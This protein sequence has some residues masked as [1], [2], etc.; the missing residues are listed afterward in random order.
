MGRG[1]DRAPGADA[2]LIGATV[3]G[4]YV[5]EARL[6]EGGMGVIY[7]ARQ[8]PLDRVV[9]LK[10]LSLRQ[11]EVDGDF[12]RRFYLEAA[13]CAK[14]SH[15]NIVVVHDYGRLEPE[16]GGACF[17]VMELVEGRTV[18]EVIAAEGPFEPMRVIRVMRDVGRALRAAHRRDVIHRD[19]KPSNVMLEKTPEGERV[20]VLDFGLVK[21]LEDDGEQITQEGE[22]L[23]SPRFMSPEQIEH[24]PLDPR[25]D[26]YSLGALAY[27]TAT[28]HAPFERPTSMSVLLAHLHDPVPPMAE[29]GVSV[30]PEIERVV[31]RC[32][33]KHP[34]DRYG[35]VEDL[36]ADLAGVWA[37][38]ADA[39]M[40]RSDAWSSISASSEI[41]RP[42][43]LT[44]SADALPLDD[45]PP[46][47]TPWVRKAAYAVLALAALA[48][49]VVLTVAIERRASG[50][51]VAASSPPAE[52]AEPPSTELASAQPPA[53]APPP[54]EE[55]PRVEV[56]PEGPRRYSLRVE[57][58]PPAARVERD[59]V[60]VGRTPMTIELDSDALEQQ[61]V[62]LTLSL[63]NHHPFTWTQGPLGRDGRILATLIR[64]DRP[65]A[66]VRA[67]PA[68]E[69]PVVLPWARPN[70]Y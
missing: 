38:L 28:G 21:V 54:V 51:S 32:L 2:S 33:E 7:R 15:A 43:A 30:P 17:M 5:V 22:F 13:T 19:L 23:G 39:G 1:L 25:S 60:L 18:A 16:H 70:P 41:Y 9:A 63:P 47:R 56:A 50:A 69:Q 6:A 66:S 4:K 10:V 55:A 48:L 20:K 26:L 40:A 65:A 35:S 27:L 34:D 36:L 58:N 37:R 42:P 67:E 46:P 53:E 14:L 62:T 29:H 12:E 31:R 3:A 57:S 24:A 68:P 11:G 8:Q 44:V 49:A 64:R 45:A 61:P 59:G 52:P